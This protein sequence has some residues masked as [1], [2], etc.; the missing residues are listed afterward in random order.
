MTPRRKST[1]GS[2]EV[3]REASGHGS[4]TAGNP[5]VPSPF[6]LTLAASKIARNGLTMSE[7]SS[8]AVS[9]RYSLAVGASWVFEKGLE[10]R[11]MCSCP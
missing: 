3:N 4:N 9:R 10:G 11:P 2:V 1:C 5:D 7:V 6:L 8:Q